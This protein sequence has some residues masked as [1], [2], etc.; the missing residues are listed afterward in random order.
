M[1]KKGFVQHELIH[2]LGFAHTQSRPDRDNYVTLHYENMKNDIR[3]K[4]QFKK[5]PRDLFSTFGLPYD[6]TSVM[7]YGEYEGSGVFWGKTISTKDP[8]YQEVIGQRDGVSIGDI[9]MINKMYECPRVC[10]NSRLKNWA[11]KIARYLYN[12][13]GLEWID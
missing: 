9:F 12:N 10:S 7:H 5:V 8:K 4:K 11:S 6:Y 13:V 3:T 1:N 2:A